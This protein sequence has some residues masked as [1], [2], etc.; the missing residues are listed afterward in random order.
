MACYSETVVQGKARGYADALLIEEAIVVGKLVVITPTATERSLA[1]VLARSTPA[2]S[3]TDCLSLVCAK[4]REMTLIMEERRGRN[5][6][7]TQGIKYVTI[8]VLPL[9]AFIAE[10]LS[11]SECY[12]M[13]NRIGRAMRT[14]EALV[15]TLQAAANEIQQLRSGSHSLR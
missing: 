5:V 12:E 14:D 11:F 4:E 10:R 15:A 3:R 13:L 6:A 9:Q 1:D 7:V 2:L 8:Q